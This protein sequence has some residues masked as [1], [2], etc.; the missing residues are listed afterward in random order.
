MILVFQWTARTQGWRGDALLFVNRDVNTLILTPN[1]ALMRSLLWENSPDLTVTVSWSREGA[2]SHEPGTERVW[3][4]SNATQETNWRPPGKVQREGTYYHSM[5]V[6]LRTKLCDF[7]FIRQ[8]YYTHAAMTHIDMTIFKTRGQELL[9]KWKGWEE[10]DNLL[11]RGAMRNIAGGPRL[12]ERRR[13]RQEELSRRQ[14]R[15]SGET[16]QVAATLG[17]Q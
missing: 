13:W 17:Q 2:M 15:W 11:T 16:G 14:E 1:S 3:P 8:V 12:A 5:S 10:V 4:L 6:S 7:F 9:L